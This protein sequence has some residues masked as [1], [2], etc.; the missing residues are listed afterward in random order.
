M[1]EINQTTSK[2][3]E[4]FRESSSDQFRAVQSGQSVQKVSKTRGPQVS[5]T[6]RNY[7]LDKLFKNTYRVRGEVRQAADWCVKVA[8]N[9][10]RRTI[11]L[12]TPNRT[13]AA[14][15]AAKFWRDLV[16][17]GWREAQRAIDPEIEKATQPVPVTVGRLIEVSRGILT[18]RDETFESYARAL[19]TLASD[20]A[21]IGEKSKFDPINGASQWRAKVDAVPLS[22]LTP[23]AVVEWRNRRLKAVSRNSAKN[24]M[25]VTV[26]SVLRCSK[27]LVSNKVRRF[28]AEKLELP[29]P[30]WFEDVPMV[31]EPSLRYNSKIDQAKLIAQ[32]NAELR[33]QQPELFKAFLL[34]FVLGLRRSEADNLLWKQFDLNAGTLTVCDTEFKKLKSKDSNGVLRIEQSVLAILKELRADSKGVFVLEAPGTEEAAEGK[35]RSPGYRAETTFAALIKW[36]RKMGVK[37]NRP[38]HT[39]RKEIGSI[40][41]SEQGIFAASRYLRHSNVSITSKLYT[42]AKTTIS[43]GLGA[44]FAMDSMPSRE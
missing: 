24:S 31:P 20:I 2:A 41:A 11:N 18:V 13:A 23:A 4:N 36:L 34:C 38:I 14:E 39:L 35:K 12:R 43:A 16:A 26:N 30:L 3:S 42:D 22:M 37:G 7:W 33:N 10:E 28:V 1:K 44:H 25:A 32:A 21:G 29:S 15:K 9:R 6:H 40:I 5:K 27:A 19:R 8:H 17:S